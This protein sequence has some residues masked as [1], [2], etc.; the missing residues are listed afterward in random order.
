LNQ[1]E[2]FAHE[3]KLAVEQVSVAYGAGAARLLALD[4]VT[5]AFP[6]AGLT[7]VTGPSGSGKTTLLSALGCLLTPDNGSVRVMGQVVTGWP[8]EHKAELR[9]RRIGFVFQAFRLF[10]SLS[11][12]EN[13]LLALDLASSRGR[14]AREAALLALEAVGLA[15]KWRLRPNELSGGEKQRVA[16]ARA[17]INDP[18][19]ILADEPTA[20]L[21]SQAGE[22]VAELL[23]NL[24]ATEQ[25][26]VVVVSHDPRWLGYSQRTITL[27]DGRVIEDKESQ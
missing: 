8:E 3:E 16:L 22:Q 17:L 27:R 19:I 14:A 20:S 18:P 13:V 25:R 9:R 1:R 26:L 12:L 4:E 11:A 21:D 10:H 7:L 6:S 15:D 24:A 23:F 2:S 5:L